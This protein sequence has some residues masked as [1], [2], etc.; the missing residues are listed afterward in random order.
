M[1]FISQFLFSLV[2][3][4]LCA[5]RLHYTTHLP[6]DDPLNGGASFYGELT[7]ETY[8]GASLTAT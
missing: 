7:E 8:F 2:L 1:T 5:A 4:G 6:A 3:F